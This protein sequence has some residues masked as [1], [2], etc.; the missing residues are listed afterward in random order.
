MSRHFIKSLLVLLLLPL[1]TSGIGAAS[2]Q[3]SSP[4]P[5]E[6]EVKWKMVIEDSDQLDLQDHWF[7]CGIKFRLRQYSD[8]FSCLDKLKVRTAKTLD[9]DDPKRVMEPLFSGF[10]YS[11][12]LME[13]GQYPEALEHAK[14]AYILFLNPQ[15]Q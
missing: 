8:L 12:A 4:I 7:S 10:L 14:A 11:T 2:K 1:A 6:W 9:A 15:V 13:L 3:P 5:D